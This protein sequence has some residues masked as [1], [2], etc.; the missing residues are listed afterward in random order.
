MVHVRNN[1]HRTIYENLLAITE[2]HLER[3]LKWR[4]IS[5]HWFK[6]KC[7]VLSVDI[8][9]LYVCACMHANV[10]DALRQ[11]WNLEN[12]TFRNGHQWQWAQREVTEVTWAIFCWS[13]N[14]FGMILGQSEQIYLILNWF[15][16]HLLAPW[17]ADL[18]S[19]S[20]FK[21]V[22]WLIN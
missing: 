11:W 6:L 22:I 16:F 10:C 15:F 21:L 4:K 5:S 8:S 17:I 13:L 7:S 14:Y 1:S 2:T 3:V 20:S 9:Y 12:H 19:F 18:I